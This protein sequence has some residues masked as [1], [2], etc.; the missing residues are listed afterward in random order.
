MGCRSQRAID[1]G[2]QPV[3][4]RAKSWPLH[5]QPAEVKCPAV[6]QLRQRDVAVTRA[7]QLGRRVELLHRAFCVG[8]YSGFGQ[9]DLVEQHQIGLRKLRSRFGR[10]A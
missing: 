8:Q 2:T 9:I 1:V 6:Q 10:I 7:L 4:C 5:A 3:G